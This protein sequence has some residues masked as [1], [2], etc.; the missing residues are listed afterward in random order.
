MIIDPAADN[1]SLLVFLSFLQEGV[2][3]VE[4]VCPAVPFQQP[5]VD[6][7]EAAASPSAQSPIRPRELVGIANEAWPTPPWCQTKAI[8]MSQL[9]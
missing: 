3:W 2:A 5:G 8:S 7:A 4:I 9:Y 6:N 1:H